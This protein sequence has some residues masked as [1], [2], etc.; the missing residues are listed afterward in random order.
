MIADLRETGELS[1]INANIAII[2][3]GAA[4]ITLAIE[5]AKYFKQVVLLESGG[6]DFE[7]GTQKLYDGS[8]L[9]APMVDPSASRLRFFGGTTNHWTGNCSP[10]DAIDFE[11]LPNRPYSG[12]P[13]RLADLIP[14]YERAYAYCEIGRYRQGSAILDRAK[15]QV[16]EILDD[17]TFGLA[18]FRHSPPTR[19]GERYRAE[20][21]SSERI[22]VYLHANVSEISISS[23]GLRVSSLKAQ[24]LT[25]KAV[26]V[27]ADAFILCCGGIENARMLLNNRQFFKNGIGNEYDLVGRF[28]TQHLE[29]AAG[30][31]LPI[32]DRFNLGLLN[33]R[34][35]RDGTVP[36][37]VVLT[38]SAQSIR[39]GR[40]SASIYFFPEFQETDFVIEA[41]N[42]PAFQAVKELV[43]QIKRGRI[44][45]DFG[46]LGCTALAD[47]AMAGKGIF[48]RIT[49]S[50][51]NRGAVKSIYVRIEGEQ[52]PN[53]DSRVILLDQVDQLGM[54]RIGID[55]RIAKED[56]DNILET[57][58][59][60][61]RGIGAKG[62]ARMQ[63]SPEEEMFQVRINPHHMGTTR[64]NVDKRQGV[65]DANCQ[66]HG[67][68]NLFIGGSSVFPTVGRVNPT[69]TLIALAIRLA[70]HLKETVKNT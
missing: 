69:V 9:G 58:T 68:S 30:R 54:R 3:A 23:N 43:T 13:F 4:G 36:V 57:A 11:P 60:L 22:R 6:F 34:S 40:K 65:V 32:D 16:A 25:G 42:S 41:E 64:M 7:E 17:T 50:Y 2:G 63:L 31:I 38:N 46:K 18:E 35:S 49:D 53:P 59:A 19:F 55:W 26:K 21:K 20:L 66:L 48:Y 47:P 56:F 51:R 5:L 33:P 29:S 28:F 27:S 52:L 1:E 15:P 8:V 14:F 44:P 39:N 10:L 12:W 67:I 70:D 45:R 37:S 62:Y 61:A 24:T